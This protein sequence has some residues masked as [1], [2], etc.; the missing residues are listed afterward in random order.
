MPRNKVGGVQ[1][2]RR[3]EPD[4]TRLEG[5]AAIVGADGVDGAQGTIGPP[6]LDGSDG[7][8]GQPGP[9][10]PSGNP[11]PTGLTGE[12]GP[13][14]FQAEE[15]EEGPPGPPGP[16]GP[17]GPAS[18]VSGAASLDF[19]AFPGSSHATVAVSA[20]T[21]TVNDKPYAFIEP[22]ATADHTLDEHC[23]E[24][25]KVFAHSVVAGVGFTIT[26]VNTSDLVEPLAP[27]K[28]AKNQTLSGQLTSKGILQLPTAGG[29]G[30]LVYGAWNIGWKY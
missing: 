17:T 3:L 4:V 28:G 23:L 25:L 18:W 21:I 1:Q 30:T 13:M 10:G 5:I 26:G 6:G 2:P 16:P 19:G 27:L 29:R 8:D 7:E 12:P 24:T 15:G 22:L 11:G 20:P 14:G 9:P